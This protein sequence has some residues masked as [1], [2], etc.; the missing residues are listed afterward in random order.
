[1]RLKKVLLAMVMGIG[2]LFSGAGSLEEL[3]EV[4]AA[5]LPIVTELEVRAADDGTGI[6]ASC[7]YQ[8]YTDQSGCEMKLYL[9]RIENTGEII[10]AEKVLAH[11][12]LGSGNTDSKEV[13]EGI[14]KASVS[15]DDGANIKQINSQNYYRVKRTDSGY[16]VT[17]DNEN[18]SV[19]QII[20]Q[21]DTVSV[22]SCSHTYEYVLEQQATPIQDAIQA[23]KCIKCG[24]ISEYVIIPNS[25]YAAFLKETVN[26]I[27]SV[28]SGEVIVR[29][30][31][32]MS[33]DRTVFE[34]IK[35]RPEVTVMVQ[36]QYRGEN[37]SFTIPKGTD[38]DLLMDENG[39]GGFRYIEGIINEKG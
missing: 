24:K 5:E 9:Y 13:A 38:V 27:Q 14:Y 37:C 16:E 19:E 39:Y 6:I 33:F 34:A 23:Y 35:S 26:S 1:M 10:E 32:W 12:D 17:K 21:Q 29:T 20:D 4:Q 2:I 8:N 11:A 31:R 25:A 22:L 7:T 36:Y 30:D 18:E 28:Q 15:I 3:L